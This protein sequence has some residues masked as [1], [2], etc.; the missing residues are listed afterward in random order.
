MSSR[1]RHIV[2][3]VTG[4]IAAYKAVELCRRL[5]DDGAFVS[6]ILTHSATEFVG[7]ATFSALASEPART[8]LLGGPE[9]SPHTDLARSTD[10]VVV[11]PATAN[12]ISS[13]AAGAAGDLLT[14]TLLATRAPVM[15]CPAMHTEMWEHPAV[16]DNIATLR[17]RGTLVVPPEEGALAGGDTGLGRLAEVEVILAAIRD[18]FAGDAEASMRGTR[19]LVTAGGTREPIDPVRYL[20]NHSSGKQGHA[21]AEEARRRG[22]EVTLVT[23]ADRPAAAG[24]RV[25]RVDTADQMHRAVMSEAATA[26]VVV[27]A[28]AVADFRPVQ[29]AAHK[30]KKAGGP[31][32]L[33][34]EPT[35]DILRE[36]VAHRREGQTIVGFAAET[37]D[38]IANAEAKLA[39]KGVDL[40]VANDVS[41][42]SVGFSHDTNAVVI[43]AADGARTDVPLAD[44]REVAAA[45]LD[46]VAH[47]RRSVAAGG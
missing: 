29:V 24:V 18:H 11:A 13:Y 32:A 27:M 15:V 25:H 10:L 31:P 22:A 30:I 20:G 16:Q 43:L 5:I 19:V 14:A 45:V 37:D 36:V 3:G 39:A 9:V 34:L 35:V 28:A 7:P 41:A 4:G 8:S 33:A 21:L 38:V 2:L 40:V 42:P 12:L 47:R 26:D 44:K 17:H 23:T 46:A 6:P 1:G